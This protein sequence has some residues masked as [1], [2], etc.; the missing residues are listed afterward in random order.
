MK[1]NKNNIQE[2]LSEISPFLAQLK[3]DETP[4]ETFNVPNDYFNQLANNIFNQ[5]ILQPEAAT[6]TVVKPI[7]PQKNTWSNIGRY[8]QWLW[9]PG[10][11]VVLTSTVILVVAGFYLMNQESTDYGADLTT[12]DIEYYI[13]TNIENFEIEQLSSLITNDDVTDVE[14]PAELKNIE[15]EAIEEYIEENFITD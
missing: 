8:F 13:E 15:S 12:A 2:E 11:A 1:D 14:I 4:I 6:Q 5:T 3:A 10:T 7:V 9:N